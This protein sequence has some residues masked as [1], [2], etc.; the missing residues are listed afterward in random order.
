[1]S[2]L[3][4]FN[5]LMQGTAEVTRYLEL[6]EKGDPAASDGLVAFTYDELQRIATQM[7][8]KERPGHTLQATALVHEAFIR[9]LGPDGQEP[10]WNSRGHFFSAAGEAMRRVLV[11]SAKR[12]LSAKRGGGVEHTIW[13]ETGIGIDTPDEQVQAID[14]ALTRLEAI[15]PELAK[16]VKLRFF[17]GMTVPQTASVLGVSPRTVNRQWECARGWLFREV[18]QT[19]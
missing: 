14:E 1:M 4:S 9:L 7:M 15:E 13:D 17:V 6:I 5:Q 2:D 16:V 18:S 10:K 19:T 12:R 11:D 3:V 8:A